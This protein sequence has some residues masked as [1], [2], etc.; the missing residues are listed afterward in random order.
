M[1]L[2]VA[3]VVAVNLERRETLAPRALAAR[4][5][6]VASTLMPLADRQSAPAAVEWMAVAALACLGVAFG[7][8]MTNKSA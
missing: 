8:A 4:V 5:A 1:A 6:V 7:L 2:I 3:A